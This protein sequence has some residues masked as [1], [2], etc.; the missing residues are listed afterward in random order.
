M[1]DVVVIL[2][3]VTVIILVAM[4][5]LIRWRL[6]RRPRPAADITTAVTDFLLPE[7]KEEHFV[8]P[9]GLFFHRGHTWVN[10]L[11]SGQVKVGVDD[12]FQRVI[13][14]LDGIALPT[15]GTELKEGQPFATIRQDGRTTSLMA[16]MDGVVCAVNGDLTRAPQLLKRDPY[17]RGW[18]VAVRPADLGQSLPRL[19][20][21]T[22]AEAWLRGEVMK[23]QKFLVGILT[24]QGD[25]LVGATA[26]DGGLHVDGLLER[27]DDEAWKQF[28]RE[29][30]GA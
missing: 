30:V 6:S 16:P 5:L 24:A 1:V 25:R 8:L 19:L 7:L 11:Y 9:A 12:F 23:L 20:I 14:R 29:F 18:L 2:L 27:L 10:L 17:T 4:D 15:V 3:I 13:G 21:G 26:A 28:Q 22:T